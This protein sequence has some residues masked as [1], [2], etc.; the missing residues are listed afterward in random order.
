MA[1]GSREGVA[2]GGRITSSRPPDDA[3]FENESQDGRS[4]TNV[5]P[6]SWWPVRRFAPQLRRISRELPEPIRARVIMEVVGDLEA[7]M[8]HH[9]A[10][11]LS[12]EEAASRAEETLLVSPE[13]L[14]HLI[15]VH[16]TPYQRWVLGAAGRLR[17]GLDLVLF[18]VGVLPILV[19]GVFVIG[20]QAPRGVASPILWLIIGCA[21]GILGI[22]A[23]K[24]HQL[25]VQRERSPARLHAGVSAVA[26]LGASGAMLGLL[27]ALLGLHRLTGALSGAAGTVTP[28]G[29]IADQAGRDATLLALGLLLAFGAG[30]IWFVLVNRIAAIER[31]ESAAFLAMEP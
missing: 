10:Q 3:A 23:V 4:S 29:A 11:G 12:E 30:I 22:A 14:R 9:R 15:A 24:L 13:A 28:P 2:A 5:Y 31:S 1:N 27:A 17:W 16:T 18:T 25:F 26:F 20:L 6:L 7:L 21:C 8:S 19:S